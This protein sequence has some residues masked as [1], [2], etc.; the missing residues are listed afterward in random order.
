MSS[1][2]QPHTPEDD[3]DPSAPPKSKLGSTEDLTSLGTVPFD[4]GCIL[5]ATWEIYKERLGTCIMVGWTVMGL[6]WGSQ[7]LQGFVLGRLLN[8]EDDQ[9]KRFLVR[10]PV[11]FVGYV[12]TTWITIGQNLAFLGLARQQPGTMERLVAGG[13]F[14]LTTLVMGLLFLLLLA[15]IVLVSLGWTPLLGAVFGSRSAGTMA[16]FA[17]GITIAAVATCYV[18]ARFSQAH[19]LI[20]DHNAGV[21]DSLRSSWEATHQ[22]VG[23]LILSSRWSSCSSWV[24]CWHAWWV[25][26]SPSHSPA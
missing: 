22:R 3:M 1:G 19:Y 4:L 10:F 14:L 17:V 13:R 21:I 8:P 20:L 15:L 2:F 11:F 23:T 26:C 25:C 16:G 7:Y 12:F 6:L 5:T 18:A 9:A 24:A